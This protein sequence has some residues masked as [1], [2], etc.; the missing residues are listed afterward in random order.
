MHRCQQEFRRTL[1]SELRHL[2]EQ[3]TYF[4]CAESAVLDYAEMGFMMFLVQG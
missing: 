2:H 4:V 1:T 3:E